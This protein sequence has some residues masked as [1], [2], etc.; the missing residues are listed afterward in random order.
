[1]V[2]VQKLSELASLDAA[3]GDF[4][5]L[6]VVHFQLLGAAG[7]AQGPLSDPAALRPF[8]DVEKPR[9]QMTDVALHPVFFQ[10][11]YLDGPVPAGVGLTAAE[12][13][14]TMGTSPHQGG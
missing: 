3:D 9:R 2:Q 8:K 11:E 7:V 5:L 4:R 1:M 12:R 13:R 10:G 6:A 14:A